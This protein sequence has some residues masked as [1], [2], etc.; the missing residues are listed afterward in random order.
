VGS[1]RQAPPETG[2]GQVAAT[3]ALKVRAAQAADDL[4]P[5]I[6]EIRSSGAVSLRQ[7]ADEMNR[8]GTSQLKI[9]ERTS[10]SKCHPAH[11]QHRV[12]NAGWK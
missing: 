4:A 2:A 7:I 11:S 10:R 3:E 6:A 1:Q 8:R 9:D 12:D 5:I